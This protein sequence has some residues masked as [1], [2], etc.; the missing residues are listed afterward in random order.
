MAGRLRVDEPEAD[1]DNPGLIED[2]AEASGAGDAEGDG[3]GFSVRRAGGVITGF[4]LYSAVGRGATVAV[5]RVGA[6][7]PPA[8][9]AFKVEDDSRSAR[10]LGGAITDGVALG[11]SVAL[12][13]GFF[14]C[15]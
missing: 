13:A 3:N 12:G 9:E 1:S 15:K 2:V 5:S 8:G 6:V 11:P 4:T 10:E 14:G 7:A